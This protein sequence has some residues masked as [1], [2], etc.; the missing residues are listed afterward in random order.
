V[1]IGGLFGKIKDKILYIVLGHLARD[2][3]EERRAQSSKL[4]TLEQGQKK[5]P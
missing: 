1:N 5:E 2:I 4:T 3:A